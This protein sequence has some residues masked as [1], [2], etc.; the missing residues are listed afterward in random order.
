MRSAPPLKTVISPSASVPMIA[1]CVVAS[2][3]VSRASRAATAAAS[4][5]R[6]VSSARAALGHVAGDGQHLDDV[7]PLVAHGAPARLEPDPAAGLVP[8]ARLL[9][10]GPVLEHGLQVARDAVAVVGV[11]DVDGEPADQ[12]L[13][14]EAEQRAAGGRDVRAYAARIDARDQ[15]A[16][17]LGQ[18]PEAPLGVGERDDDALLLGHVAERRHDTGDRRRRRAARRALTD[19]QRSSPW[20]MCRPTSCPTTSRPVVSATLGRRLAGRERRA[21]AA[22]AA[23]L[24]GGRGA[25]QLGARPAQDAPRQPG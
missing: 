13:G 11:E 25:D 12:L 14:L 6:S 23:A 24:V 22:H 4:L 5:A 8:E 7:A 10:R 15:V 17:V 20:S 3:T 19:I 2:S 9:A 16:R 1:Y 18:Q 21:V